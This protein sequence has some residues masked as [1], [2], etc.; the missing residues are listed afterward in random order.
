[1]NIERTNILE[2]I[3]SGKNK[4]HSCVITSYSIDLWFFEQTVL[5]K[6]RAAGVTNIN[7]FIDARMLE[8]YLSTHLCCSLQK[9][10]ANYSITPVNLNGAFHPKMMM[11]IGKDKGYLSIGSGNIT[12]SGMLYNDEIW[13]SFYYSTTKQHTASIF[14]DTW[15]FVLQLE[16]RTSG[17][18]SKKIGWISQHASWLNSLNS[19]SSIIDDISYQWFHSFS[20]KS[21]YDLV[22]NS[23]PRKPKSIKV[24]GPYFNKNGAFISQL[25]RDLEPKYIHCIIDKEN[26]IL[27]LGFESDI[28]C[29]FSDWSDVISST[30]GT[31]IQRLHAKAIQVEYESETIFILGSA[32][33]T[34]EA[35]G[36][37][38]KNSKNSEAI[39][40]IKKENSDD[41]FKSLGI[42]IPEKGTLELHLLEQPTGIDSEVF[43]VKK[44]VTL[45]HAELNGTE[46]FVEAF[47]NI[48]PYGSLCIYDNDNNDIKRF[49]LSD[50]ESQDFIFSLD[51][52]NAFK[53]AF[54]DED[55]RISNFALIQNREV[56]EKSNPDE[57]LAR[58]LSFEHLDIFNSLNY[59]LVLD[60]ME[61]ERVFSDS[62]GRAIVSEPSEPDED[63]GE[64]LSELEYNRNA[65]LSIEQDVPINNVTSMIEEFLD[66]LKIRDSYEEDFSDNS[67]TLALEA[68][69]DGLAEEYEVEHQKTNITTSEGERIQRKIIKTIQSINKLIDARFENSIPQ[70]QRTLNA[71]FIGFHI[72]MHFWKEKY[73]EEICEIKL[74]Y[75]DL[76]S[77]K[78]LEKRFNLK[79]W[80]SQIDCKNNE[81]GY[82]IGISQLDNILRDLDVVE[83]FKLSGNISETKEILHSFIKV[84]YCRSSEDDNLCLIFID[85][86]YLNILCAIQKSELSLNKPQ[87]IKF[88]ILIM[89]L[90]DDLRWKDNFEYWRDLIILNT[91]EILEIETFL[92]DTVLKDELRQ[93]KGGATFILISKYIE[94]KQSFKSIVFKKMSVYLAGSFIYSSTYGF[95]RLKTVRNNNFIDLE[96]PIGMYI[97]HKNYTGYD[98]VFIGEKAKFFI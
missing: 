7:L 40:V 60:F 87:K 13:S 3:G 96:S 37:K 61:S 72:L 28:D 94:Y 14:K 21:L 51:N 15:S 83:G 27:P 58:L 56:L 12:S 49:D 68:G 9:F 18:N 44:E 63:K 52:D 25:I 46:L 6:L 91:C 29:Q 39:I 32:N 20:D 67:E 53:C 30:N 16:E 66:V 86:S 65:S 89:K 97:G 88:F 45:K 93:L 81:V 5:P 1:M 55:K 85:D 47:F 71:L 11:L 4:Y 84:K 33:P 77:L 42:E 92:V 80:E 62:T 35:F 90:L 75:T 64:V 41:T 34:M 2:L 48:E 74:K 31:S 59:E 82:Y 79:R 69:D 50:L 36:A 57:R 73:S 43:S 95:C 54:Y 78:K 70:D 19:G 10:K 26:G 22:F 8:K 23:F 98:E 17:I 38:N 76:K 24:I